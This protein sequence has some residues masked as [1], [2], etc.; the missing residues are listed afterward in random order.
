M[1]EAARFYGAAERL[2]ETINS[3]R[4]SDPADEVEHQHYLAIARA[5]ADPAAWAVAWAEGRAL[6]PLVLDTRPPGN[7]RRVQALGEKP[8]ASSAAGPGASGSSGSPGSSDEPG[9]GRRGS[10]S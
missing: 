3:P 6:P 5:R 7:L 10:G 9:G 8:V 4:A 2:R 1:R